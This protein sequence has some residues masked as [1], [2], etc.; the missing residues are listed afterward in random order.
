MRLLWFMA[1]ALLTAGCQA[2]LNAGPDASALNL[3]LGAAYLAQGRL[4]LAR[5]KLLRATRQDPDSSE[6][7]RVLGMAYE[8]LEDQERA[9]LHYRHAVRLAPRDVEALNSLGVFQCRRAGMPREGLKLLERAAREAVGIRR[10]AVYVNSG[11]CELPLNREGAE[12][13]FRRALAID[14]LHVEAQLL[15]ERLVAQN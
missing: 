4:E 2:G 11:M 3:E 5:D 1:A 15:L 9:G 6:A 13:W 8:R 14:P 7:H 12:D 10:A